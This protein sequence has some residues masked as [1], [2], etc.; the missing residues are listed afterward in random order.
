MKFRF[1]TV[2][3]IV[4]FFLM[5]FFFLSY[6]KYK[7]IYSLFYKFIY[8]AR[9]YAYR[10]NFKKFFLYD[11]F[12]I[13]F[14]YENSNQKLSLLHYDIILKLYI[15]NLY[16]FFDFKIKKIVILKFDY[17][18]LGFFIFPNYFINNFLLFIFRYIQ[19]YLLWIHNVYRIEKR[20]IKYLFK[21][22]IIDFYS[23]NIDNFNIN[24]FFFKV[25]F[26]K[27][28]FFYSIFFGLIKN[29]TFF[30][31]KSYINY[32]SE[33]E[34]IK[35]KNYYKNYIHNFYRKN[36]IHYKFFSFF[37]HSKFVNSIYILKTYKVNNYV[38]FF[39]FYFLFKKFIYMYFFF[40]I[41]NT[42]FLYCKKVATHF[43]KI[44]CFIKILHI[45]IGTWWRGFIN[46][47]F[48]IKE[49]YLNNRLLI[50]YVSSLDKKDR[51]IPN[52]SLWIERWWWNFLNIFSTVEV[53]WSKFKEYIINITNKNLRFIDYIPCYNDYKEPYY[54]I[55]ET[56]MSS[57]IPNLGYTNIDKN[58]Q[59]FYRLAEYRASSEFSNW[60]YRQWHMYYF[61]WVTY[62]SMTVES[63]EDKSNLTICNGRIYIEKELIV[64]YCTKFIQ[65]ILFYWDNLQ[66][67]YLIQLDYERYIKDVISPEIFFITVD[68]EELFGN[69]IESI[70]K[71]EKIWT[72][73]KTLEKEMGYLCKYYNELTKKWYVKNYYIV[74]KRL[75]EEIEKI[76][77]RS[78]LRQYNG[79]FKNLGF[80]KHVY[81]AFLCKKDLNLYEQKISLMQFR[82]KFH[83]ENILT[84]SENY[85]FIGASNWFTKSLDYNAAM[86][87]MK[88]YYNIDKWSIKKIK[89]IRGLLKIFTKEKVNMSKWCLNYEN[90]YSVWFKN[91]NVLHHSMPI[92]LNGIWELVW[93]SFLGNKR[94]KL[95]KCKIGFL[96]FYIR[97]HK[98]LSQIIEN[99]RRYDCKI[100]KKKDTNFIDSIIERN[101]LI[102]ESFHIISVETSSTMLSLYLFFIYWYY[103]LDIVK[104]YYF[105][106]K[107]ILFIYYLTPIILKNI[108]FIPLFNGGGFIYP[109]IYN[110][111]SY[112]Y[113]INNYLLRDLNSDKKQSISYFYL[114]F[115]H[116]LFHTEKIYL[117]CINNKIN[118]IV[119]KKSFFILINNELLFDFWLIERKSRTSFFKKLKHLLEYL[120]DLKNYFI[121]ILVSKD[122]YLFSIVNIF[123]FYLK[124]LLLFISLNYLTLDRSSKGLYV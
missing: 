116:L 46:G 22:F 78:F 21:Q 73:L 7:L 64:W 74:D 37:F 35:T 88:Y 99:F 91:L 51:S 50:P 80:T 106:F 123:Y 101:S 79:E 97:F 83:I 24:L 52:Y 77:F 120:E 85:A 26:L 28:Y 30:F 5:L 39:L 17:K 90:F 33:F 65:D 41:Q 11:L 20:K 63:I 56:F 119:F 40:A 86:L 89:K 66:Q 87:N 53:I 69:W 45:E 111:Y 122:K 18:K 19:I 84:S 4:E 60:L 105:Y 115:T 61:Y 81:A 16:R 27:F 14:L 44:L 6:V 100:Y 75:I 1:S 108:D 118:I 47:F 82:L 8:N 124:K 59:I 49:D 31:K 103:K 15:N 104:E 114:F 95:Y 48:T 25:L 76:G 10:N 72:L 36:I 113:S 12:L 23:L 98:D 3:L 34:I 57:P 62:L 110:F 107:T 102:I 70:K 68:F 32:I 94:S 38:Y 58:Q 9:I 43:I 93:L 109:R 55:F 92:D 71:I 2:L 112:E 121:F 117:W 67:I 13:F 54:I 29:I 42:N 96:D